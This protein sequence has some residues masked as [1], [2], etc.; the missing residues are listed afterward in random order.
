[1]KKK[2]V[3]MPGMAAAMAAVGRV[4]AFIPREAVKASACGTNNHPTGQQRLM[5]AIML[6]K[7]AYH[8]TTNGKRIPK[9]PT[10]KQRIKAI[11]AI[12]RQR[13]MM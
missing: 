11:N 5:H 6:T 2:L 8:Q 7:E 4:K 1:M 13:G 10:K 12:L 3:M 9:M